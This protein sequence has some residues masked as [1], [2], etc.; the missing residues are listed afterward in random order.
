MSQASQIAPLARRL[1]PESASGRAAATAATAATAINTHR[2]NV[3]RNAIIVSAAFIAS[4]IL[5]LVREMVLAQRF[6]TTGIYDAY[7]SAFRIPDLL[8]LV[9]MAGSFGAA[10]IPVFGGYL[11]QHDQRKAWNLASAV[12]TWAGVGIAAAA[13]VCF[14][15]AR[16]LMTWVVA[17]GLAPENQDAAV[18]LMRILLLSPAF[19]GFGIAAKG[20]LEAHHRFTLPALAPVLYNICIILGALFLAPVYGI[21]GVAWSVIAGAALHLGVQ[22]PGLVRVGMRFHPTLD[23]NVA[24]LREVGRLLL[25]RVIGQAAFQINFIAVNYFASRSGHEEVSALNYA[26]Q[27][28]MLPHGVLA[29]SI[30]TVIFPTLSLLYAQGRTDEMRETVSE[31]LRPLLFLTVPASL[32]LLFLRDP[33]VTVAFQRGAFDS[34]STHLVVDPLVFFAIGLTGYGVVEIITRVYYATRDTRTPVVTGVLIIGLNILLCKLFVGDLRQSGLALALSATT[35]AEAIILLLFLRQRLDGLFDAAFWR[36]LA[37]LLLANAVFG[38]LLWAFSGIATDATRAAH[39]Q[40]QILAGVFL[41]YAIAVFLFAYIVIAKLAGIPE[42]Q[43]M[44]GKFGRRLPGPL[45]RLFTWF[46]FA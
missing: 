1:A 31:N 4:R 7:V 37:R 16:P 43:M 28:M 23:R 21:Y 32:G 24:G 36:W 15:L 34:H 29:L 8:F 13:A 42:L 10:F 45:Y 19:L 11:G 30:S 35:A 25:P 44:T 6:G 38:A 26:W 17:P 41:L 18:K 33:I 9:I 5:G 14:I 3:A 2:Q 39:D 22:I 20:I 27:L 12:L 40:N 46:G